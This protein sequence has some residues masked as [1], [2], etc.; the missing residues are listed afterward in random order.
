MRESV[1][2]VDAR[3]GGRKPSKTMKVAASLFFGWTG[4]GCYPKLALL[5]AIYFCRSV[6]LGWY[7]MLPPTPVSTLAFRADG[8]PLARRR[9]A[10]GGRDHRNVRPA[11]AGHDPGPRLFEPPAQAP[12]AGGVLFDLPGSY[13]FAWQLAVVMGLTGGL[14]QVSFALLRPRLATTG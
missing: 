4:G 9:A 5:G 3:M 12:S 6:V 7:F 14:V 2:W 13:D 8:L 11:L 10:G 1:G